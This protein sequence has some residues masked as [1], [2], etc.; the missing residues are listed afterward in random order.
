MVEAFGAPLRPEAAL[1][2]GPVLEA[3]LDRKRKIAG[4]VLHVLDGDEPADE[5]G[6]GTAGSLP[7]PE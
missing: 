6:I 2:R 7:C 3:P 5:G 4:A 1:V